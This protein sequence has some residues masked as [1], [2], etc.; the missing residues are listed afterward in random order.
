MIRS[1]LMFIVYFWGRH[2]FILQTPSLI[3]FDHW[4]GGGEETLSNG[5]TAKHDHDCLW[6]MDFDI[7]LYTHPGLHMIYADNAIPQVRNTHNPMHSSL[8]VPCVC[9]L[10]VWMKYKTLGIFEIVIFKSYFLT[11]SFKLRGLD[12]DYYCEVPKL[13]SLKKKNPC[14]L[15]TSSGFWS[16]QHPDLPTFHCCS[17][18]YAIPIHVWHATYFDWL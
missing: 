17:Q 2:S 3:R 16:S 1:W 10:P 7:T 14:F 5:N 8:P 4:Q 11:Y 18:G 12:T 9:G 6:V 13:A 15:C